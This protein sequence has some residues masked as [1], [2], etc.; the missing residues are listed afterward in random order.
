VRLEHWWYTIP[1]RVRSIFRRSDIEQELDDELRLHLE[2]QI[3]QEIA[4]GKTPEDAR[5]AA[6]RAMGGIEQRKEECR[7]MRRVNLVEDLFRDLRFGLRSLRKSPAF[8][9]IAVLTLTLG[10]GANTAIFSVV[11][12]VLLRPLPYTHPNQLVRLYETNTS[13]TDN[14]DSVSAPNFVDWQAQARTF[15]AMG[16]LVWEAVTLTGGARPESLYAQRVTTGMLSML[17]TPPAVGRD[18]SREDAVAGRDHVVLLSHEF[19]IKHFAGEQEAVGQH[20]KLNF[21]PYTVIGVLPPGFRTPS[22]FGS[23]EPLGLLLPL[24]FS[25]ADLQNRGSHNLQVFA[26]LGP[27]VTPAL[28]QTEMSEVAKSL[29]KTYSNQQGR[30]ARVV[31][32][33]DEIVGT[34]RTSL[35]MILCASGLILLISCAN[36]ANA[37]LARGVG[38]QHEIAVR[39]ALG[40]S[41]ISIVRQVLV[42]NLILAATGCVTGVVTAFWIV[43]SL[44]ALAPAQLPRIDEVAVDLQSLAFAVGASIFTG[45][46]FGLL[47]AF[48]L[49]GYHPYDAMKG[50]GA[51]G[52]RSTVLRWRNTL[53]VAQVMLSVVLLVGAGLLLKSFA[54]LRGIDIGFQPSRTLAM[55]IMLPRT[56]YTD[57][58]K[59]LQFFAALAA[60][61]ENLPG[62][63]AVGYTNQLPMRGGWG[64][65][66]RIE[67]PEVAMG[68]NDD[69]DFQLVNAGYFTALRINL[70][71]GRLF[72]DYDTSGSAPVVI[73]NRA[74]AHRYWPNSDP[75]GQRLFKGNP[76]PFRIVGVVDDV[77]LGG[78]AQ[79]ANIEIYFA[80][81]QAESLPVA[82]SDLAVRTAA[83]PLALLNAIQREV[84]TLDKDQPVTAVR[85]LDEVL[86][87]STSAA[88]FNMLLLA[89]FAALALLLAAVG[90]YGVVS[91]SIAQRAP[92][93][94]IRIAV[95]ASP[96]DILGL[97][98]REITSLV[99]VGGILGVG[100]SLALSRYV[101]SMLFGVAPHDRTAFTVAIFGLILV[102]LVAAFIPAR[103]ALRID[104]ITVLRVE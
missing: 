70:L 54:R 10:I 52:A 95:G 8:T 42:Q 93:I 81:T 16:A 26:R 76:A 27:G 96:A 39:F 87:Q 65:S 71:R 24:T 90:I 45:L 61:I 12:T 98:L 5:C 88:R 14:R 89:L 38:R 66:F 85:T 51:G 34:Y 101:A 23:A 28:A 15:S 32:L 17:G 68:P 103:R 57:Q 29:A 50:R 9:A 1:L 33:M 63:R 3:A 36:L 86:A 83:D 31:P 84:W 67:S 6:L 91:Y 37:L 69:S 80:A 97:V 48:H 46:A 55:R 100:V 43:K 22:Q 40:A 104:P 13:I 99:A 56:K 21:E 92:E 2:Q 25:N 30:S 82:P 19:W 49:S 59:R 44:H 41:R 73:V 20:I 7:D 18:F 79:P 60:R 4:A 64:G 78:P 62:V 11:N 35:L 74:F 77:H 94:G 72:N 102:G 47:P 53:V 75:I 58:A